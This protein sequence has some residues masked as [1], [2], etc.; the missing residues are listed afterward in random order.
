MLLQLLAIPALIVALSSLMASWRSDR[1]RTWTRARWAL[2][3]CFAIAI[4]PLVQLVP[5]PPWIWQ[6]LPG[7]QAVNEVFD[8]L[9]AAR[10]WMP[11]SVSPNATWLGFLLLLPPM[12]VFLG[13]IQL[14]YRER[15]ALSVALIAFGVVSAFLGLLQ[16][17]QGPSSALRFF[18]FTN[19]TEAV[20]FFANR[21]HL[22]ALLYAILLFAFAWS[23]D[24]AFKVKL[25]KQESGFEPG[26]IVAL[27]ASF[28]V[29]VVLIAAEATARS[30]AGLI[31]MMVAVVGGFALVLAG[32]RGQTPDAAG[33]A[34][35]GRFLAGAVALAVLLVVQFALYRIL[36]RFGVDPLEDARIGFARDTIQAASAFMPFGSGIGTFVPV[37]GMFEEPRY[38][39]I[40]TYAN[41]AHNDFLELWLEAGIPGMMILRIRRLAGVAIDNGLAH[42][43]ARRPSARRLARALGHHRH[44]ADCGAFLRRLSAAD[45][46][47]HGGLCHGVRLAGGTAERSRGASAA[48]RRRDGADAAAAAH[49]GRFASA[50][51]T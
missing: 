36:D 42:A 25:G 47:H 27:T 6:R 50:C 39:L 16:V 38:L 48:V 43:S 18:S 35:P 51:R 5:L 29:P 44:C 10:P 11:I 9:G 3:L 17:A 49:P 34:G 20:G 15:R 30:R 41:H 22:A 21:N 31:L 8:L 26:M 12:A 1:A 33:K 24:I 23:I 45:R 37:Y 32:Q 28:M 14:G 40:G 13:V 7:R 4:L 2:L 19:T 46:R